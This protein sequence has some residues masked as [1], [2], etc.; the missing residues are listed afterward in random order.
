MCKRLTSHPTIS[1]ICAH[2]PLMGVSR[3]ARVHVTPPRALPSHENL[4]VSLLLTIFPAKLTSMKGST[5]F[6]LLLSKPKIC[7]TLSNTA[8][9]TTEKD[10][11]V[12]GSLLAHLQAPPFCSPI[13]KRPRDPRETP[14]HP[15]SPGT[16]RREGSLG[17]A[18]LE[19]TAPAPHPAPNSS[20]TVPLLSKALG[21]GPPK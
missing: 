16:P 10:V 14:R 19:G 18:A 21:T 8:S 17:T 4:P 2:S 15:R 1:P 3:A 11:W 12:T 5:R 13:Y 9:S 7:F 6:F 20:S